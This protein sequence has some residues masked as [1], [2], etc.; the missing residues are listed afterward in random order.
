M[1]LSSD[2]YIHIHSS[3]VSGHSHKG[4]S[5]YPGKIGTPEETGIHPHT[6]TYAHTCSHS[7]LTNV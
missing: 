7:Q 6:L 5:Y 4:S 2:H 1:T 3:S